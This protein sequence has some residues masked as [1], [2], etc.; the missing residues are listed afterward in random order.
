MIFFLEVKPTLP[1]TGPVND[2]QW[3]SILHQMAVRF[4]HST[5]S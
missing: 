2:A 1:K 5:I 4:S 3:M